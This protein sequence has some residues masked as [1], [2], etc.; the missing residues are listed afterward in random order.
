MV[1]VFGLVEFETP[2]FGIGSGNMIYFL[3]A[4]MF[5][6]AGAIIIYV[7]YSFKI[8][9]KKIV[10][11]ENISGQGY[12]VSYK[13]RARLIDIGDS[14]EELLFLKKRKKYRTA[15]GKKM[16]KNTYW[17]A[18]GQDGY[19]YN[20]VLGDVDAK[21]GMLDI[22]PIDRDM[23][24]MHVAVRK[25]IQDRYRKVK[26]M[27]K[28]GAIVFSGIFLV[29]ML[30]GIWFLLDKMSDIAT[31][32]AGA[33]QGAEGVQEATRQIVSSLD[34]ILDK[35]EYTGGSGIEAG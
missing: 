9:N 25:N 2:S 10:V 13:D 31:A 8:F 30:I 22:E 21:M 35:F 16:G 24:Y 14:G 34:H 27:E 23:R 19:W 3:I 7:V 29:I 18:I 12:Q 11:F 17:F 20:V 6:L 15:Y 26:F 28:Y 5:L 32:N 33:V 1:D 4:F